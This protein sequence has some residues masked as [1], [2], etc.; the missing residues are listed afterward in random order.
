MRRIG[1]AVLAAAVIFILV[2]SL[3]DG[4]G[5]EPYRFI[6]DG[7]PVAAEGPVLSRHGGLMVSLPF[8]ERLLHADISWGSDRKLPPGVYYRN[9]VA[10]LMYHHLSEGSQPRLPGVLPADRFKAQM[11]LLKSE[12]YRVITMKQ[13]ER[14]MQ[15]EGAVPDNAVLLTFDDGYESFYK[16]AYPVLRRYGYSAV[17]FVIVS[18]VDHPSR[19][20][21]PKLT[22]AQ[23][24]EMKKHGM[25]FYDHTYDLHRYEPVD[26]DGDLRPALSSLLYIQGEDRNETNEEYY[27]RVEKDLSHAESRL[28]QELG[29]TDS[30]IAYPYGSATARTLQAA[31]AVGIR[32]HFTIREGMAT[33]GAVNAPR[34]NAGSDRRSA[35]EAIDR[36]RRLVPQKQ[37]EVNG[38][39]VALPGAQPELR[40]GQWMVPLPE[41]CQ[42]LGF[43]LD[44]SQGGG[45]VTLRTVT[46]GRAAT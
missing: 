32:L 35:Q 16:L 19:G 34:I 45:A 31:E 41:L 40:K 9:E 25:G 17:N 43:A 38:W 44:Y 20:G 15:G 33:R 5:P 37:L 11:A 12:G 21:V 8:A 46:A 30:A 4:W 3:T 24:R 10:V 36:I 26:G 2:Q 29:N 18:D 1:L 14:F 22:W 28:R 27:Q 13:Y 39:P 6:R 7:R 23:M 42:A